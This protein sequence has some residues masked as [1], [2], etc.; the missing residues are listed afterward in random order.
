MCPTRR[1]FIHNDC[2]VRDGFSLPL[3]NV[4]LGGGGVMFNDKIYNRI[5]GKCF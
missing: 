4:L 5:K 3:S 1:V 2:P